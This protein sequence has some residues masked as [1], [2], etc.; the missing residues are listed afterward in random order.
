LRIFA[1]GRTG[2]IGKHLDGVDSLSIRFPSTEAQIQAELA[3]R[4]CDTLIHLAAV[5]NPIQVA[6]D[7][8]RSRYVNVDAPVVL[9]KAFIESGGKRFVFASTGHVYGPQEVGHLSLE[10]DTPHPISV[11]ANQKLRAESALI[12]VAEQHEIDL[13]ILRI[14]SVFGSSMARHYLA[15]TVSSQVGKQISFP[16]IHNSEDVRD[17]STPFWVA[18]KIEEFCYLE[19]GGITICNIAS[20]VPMSIR[21]KVLLE[22]PLWPSNCF[23]GLQS[24]MSWLV[25][26]NQLLNELLL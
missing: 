11:Y 23:D 20:G 12:E 14:F 24:N 7:E 26:S 18:K 10:T 22:F 21:G 13:T 19:G 25:G 8:I 15:G 17:F 1:T 2:S 9:L 4:E 16:M 5:T 3:Y 6:Q